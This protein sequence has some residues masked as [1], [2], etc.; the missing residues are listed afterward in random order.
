[1]DILSL[2]KNMDKETLE[3]SIRQAQ[4]F[5]STPEGQNAA[6]ML[7]DG[8]MPDGGSIPE[9][10]KDAVDAIGN[11]KNAQNRQRTSE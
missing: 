10:L 5:L 8:K 6:K 9:E 11:N 2:L 1:M 3:N 4:S 7:S